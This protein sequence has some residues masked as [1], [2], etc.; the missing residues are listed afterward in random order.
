[1]LYTGLTS[2]DSPTSP[3]MHHPCSIG[4]STLL[5]STAAIT[6]RSIARSVI[7]IPPAMLMNTSFCMSLK[8]TRFSSTASS[9]LSRRWSKPVAER[10]GV[11]Y[12]AVDTRACVSTRKGRIPSIVDDI[13]IPERSSW[14]RVS[15]S[16]EGFDTCRSPVCCIS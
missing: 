16:S 3:H 8:P 9:I 5:D 7:R 4:V 11:P 10:C 14:L 6:E 15:S 13:A 2:P 12:A 1:M